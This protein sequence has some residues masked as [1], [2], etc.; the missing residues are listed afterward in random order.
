MEE[1]PGVHRAQLLQ[2][3]PSTLR[4]RLAPAEGVEIERLWREVVVALR[5]YLNGQGLG[6]VDIVRAE[7]APE[8]SGTS[9]K[10]RQVI[11][12]TGP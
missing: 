1:V 10:F 2:T 4:L 12:A 9:G 5:S 7:E 6:Q 3:G 8:Q 11:R